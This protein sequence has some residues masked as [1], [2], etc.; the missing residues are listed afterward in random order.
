MNKT[1]K[2]N[3]NIYE[4]GFSDLTLDLLR[5]LEKKDLFKLLERSKFNTSLLIAELRDRKD[6]GE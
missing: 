2:E 3:I 4:I 6:R 5:T 1:N